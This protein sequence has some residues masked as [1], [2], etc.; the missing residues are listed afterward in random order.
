M[1]QQYSHL[2]FGEKVLIEKLHCKQHLSVRKTT[3][4]IGRGKPTV[5]NVCTQIET[6]P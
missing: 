5:P 1:G 3:E 4:R 2:S 6:N